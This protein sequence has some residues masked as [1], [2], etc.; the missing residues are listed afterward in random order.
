MSPQSEPQG[1]KEV[2]L[3]T[4]EDGYQRRVLADSVERAA[5]KAQNL[6][7]RL[8]KRLKDVVKKNYE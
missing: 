7:T 8:K 2:Y 4:M 1:R 5:W 3:I 6:A